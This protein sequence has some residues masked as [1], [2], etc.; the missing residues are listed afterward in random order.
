MSTKRTTATENVC[1]SS[2]YSFWWIALKV[3][4][5]SAVHWLLLLLCL[6]LYSNIFFW[7]ENAWHQ[8]K[9]IACLEGSW[10][11]TATNF[12]RKRVPRETKRTAAAAICQWLIRLSCSVK[13]IL[14]CS[15]TVRS[16]SSR[17]NRHPKRAQPVTSSTNFIFYAN[18]APLLLMPFSSWRTI[19]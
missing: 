19:R 15:C 7:K 11:T 1:F 5:S 3:G 4:A 12:T 6:P 9:C 16:A 8:E 10:Y 14:S 2:S 18:G 13:E 17:R